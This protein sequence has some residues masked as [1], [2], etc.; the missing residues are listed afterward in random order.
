MNAEMNHESRV[1]SHGIDYY[2]EKIA[3]FQES[4]DDPDFVGFW[5]LCRQLI[6]YCEK[7]IWQLLTSN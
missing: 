2:E 3:Y 4:L 1:T 6:G 5:D 7:K